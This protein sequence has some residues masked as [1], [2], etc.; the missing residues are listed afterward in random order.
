MI[1]TD[2]LFLTSGIID[3]ANHYEV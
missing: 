1:G 3:F 2:N